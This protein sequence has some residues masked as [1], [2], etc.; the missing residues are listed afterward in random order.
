[1]PLKV[2]SNLKEH[3]ILH[4]SE[5]DLYQQIRTRNYVKS[6]NSIQLPPQVHAVETV[7]SYV[8]DF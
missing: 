5:K 6:L 2:Y 8:I 4:L 3:D 7:I 1:M